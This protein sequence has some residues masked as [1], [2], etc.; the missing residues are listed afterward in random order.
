MKNRYTD[1]FEKERKKL[2]PNDQKAVDQKIKLLNKCLT[3]F[4]FNI[5]QIKTIQGF[6][7]R[8]VN[9]EGRWRMRTSEQFRIYGKLEGD[10]ET[11]TMTWFAIRKH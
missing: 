9:D 5:E 1:D 2:H 3:D 10:W 8:E 4:N 6:R 11:G 7:L